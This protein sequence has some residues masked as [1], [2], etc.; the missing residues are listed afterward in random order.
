MA[1]ITFNGVDLSS[2]GL[3]TPGVAGVHD[4][5]A[6]EVSR[7]TIPGRDYPDE[8]DQ[9]LSMRTL[10]FSCVVVGD[11]HADLVSDLAV[12][13]GHLSP[14]LGYRALTITD[15]ADKRIMARSQGFPVRIDAIPYWAEAVEFTLKFAA[16][17]WWE[18]ASEQCD[19]VTAISDTVT[20]GGDLP[21]YPTYTCTVTAAL[22]GGLYFEIS[23]E[24]FT[25]EGALANTDV[26]I[27]YADPA[28]PDVTLNG[29]RDFAN[30]A[31]D[32][33]FPPLLVGPNTVALSS[34][35]FSLKVDRRER[36]L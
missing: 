8:T 30:V 9:R 2:Y 11:D 31:D 18:D 32:A 22:A 12:L 16:Y 19:T 25:Y 27:I 4:L 3:V 26:L 36:Y 21:C 20:N 13:K 33:E 5:P 10:V 17:P 34:T 29:S 28:A 14:T 35:N 23:G 15:L 1:N 24:R 7:T 6:M